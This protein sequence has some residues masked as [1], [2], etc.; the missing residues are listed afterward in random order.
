MLVLHLMVSNMADSI[1]HD[2][3]V[4]EF[5]EELKKFLDSEC[6]TIF[7]YR[8]VDFTLEIQSDY[9]IPDFVLNT[10]RS[11]AKSHGYGFEES[12]CRCRFEFH[13]LF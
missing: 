6:L 3:T 7:D 8:C 5:Y 1:L 11:L 13:Q 2:M 12:P 10:L 9:I 4:Q